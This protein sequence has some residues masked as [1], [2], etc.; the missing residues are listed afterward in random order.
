MPVIITDMELPKRCLDCQLMGREKMYCQL[1]PRK[2]LN[3]IRVVSEKPDWCPL[4]E[5]PT[6]YWKEFSQG[7]YHGQ[8]EYGEPIWRDV[9]VRHCSRCNRRTV[10]K[11]NYCPNCGSRM[12][13]EQQGENT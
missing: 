3:V 5:V 11:E 10:I 9:I 4:K 1:H 2:D 7:A 8:D 13:E 12:V 6:A